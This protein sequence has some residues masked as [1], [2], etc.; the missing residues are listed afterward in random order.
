M[1]NYDNKALVYFQHPLPQKWQDQPYLHVKP[2]YGPKKQYSQEEDNSPA[3]DKAR[4]NS[5]RKYVEYF[6]CLHVWLIEDYFPA[7]SSLAS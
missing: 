3:L 7:L 1:P 6:F 5:S 2:K 4:K